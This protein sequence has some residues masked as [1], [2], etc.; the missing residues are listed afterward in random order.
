MTDRPETYCT[1]IEEATCDVNCPLRLLRNEVVQEVTDGE[2][3]LYVGEGIHTLRDRV[4]PEAAA[5]HRTDVGVMGTDPDASSYTPE[6]I[7]VVLADPADDFARHLMDT[8]MTTMH[9]DQPVGPPNALPG[10]GTPLGDVVTALAG[11]IRRQYEGECT[12]DM[13]A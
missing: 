4:V 8:A 11:C 9:V 13:P 7:E 12:P 1:A 6:Y 10:P 3:P 2:L 5:D